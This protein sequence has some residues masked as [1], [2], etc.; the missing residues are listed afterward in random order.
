[1]VD[2][3]VVT[4]VYRELKSLRDEMV[5]QKE[6]QRTI[7]L[8]ELLIK[9]TKIG[10]DEVEE[11]APVVQPSPLKVADHQ[12]IANVFGSACG[13]CKLPVEKWEPTKAA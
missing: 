7:R 4:E 1:M 6:N 13:I 3:D 11:A 10:P 2:Q 12:H 5:T 9:L 8:T